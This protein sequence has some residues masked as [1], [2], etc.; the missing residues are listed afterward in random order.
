MSGVRATPES[1]RHAGLRGFPAEDIYDGKP[2]KPV[3]EPDDD[4][5]SRDSQAILETANMKPGLRRPLHI[6]PVELRNFMLWSG[7]RRCAHRRGP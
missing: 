7:I 2:A 4:P 5:E 6:W 1:D 3:L